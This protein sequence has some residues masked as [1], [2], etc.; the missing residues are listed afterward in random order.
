MKGV[1]GLILAVGLGVAAALFNFAYLANKS[2]K[3]ELTS[4]V[5][6]KTNLQ[7]GERL[8][9]D[10]LEEVRVPSSVAGNLKDYAVLWSARNAEVDKR[11]WRAI[12]AG[13]L[14]MRQD[15]KAPPPELVFGQ[16]PK[17]GVDERAIGVPIDPRK[18][19]PSL[20]QPGD[21]VT[22]VA[23][24]SAVAQPRRAPPAPEASKAD[25]AGE[26]GKVEPVPMPGSPDPAASPGDLEM[27]GPFKVLSLGNRLTAP[28]I[29]Q[30]AQV[31]QVQ[32]SVMMIL[33]RIENGRFEPEAEKLLKLL[34]VNRSQ[35]LVVMLHPRQ[36]R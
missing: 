31:P 24:T 10:A 3:V 32:E 30:S 28:D 20:I 5:G 27:I 9:Q 12:P 2:G 7:R 13:S 22:F 35:P 1:H 14:L 36:P 4:F 16:D 8:R 21:L 11:V 29:L 17:P 34:E 25:R 19:V 26:S 6:V 23:S 33:V 18:I 15:L